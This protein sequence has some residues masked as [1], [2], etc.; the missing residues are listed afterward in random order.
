MKTPTR[1]EPILATHL[2]ARGARLGLPIAGNFELTARCNFSCP[3]CYVHK[4]DAAVPGEL[5]A[6]QWI[7][8]AGQARDAGMIF[9]LLTGGEPFVRKDFWEI[10]GA[11]QEMGLMVSINSNGSLIHGKTLERLL[12]DPPFRINISLYGGC[13]ETYRSMCGQASFASVVEAIRA[14]KEAGVDTRLNVSITPYNLQDLDR[15]WE[16]SQELG[17]HAKATSY[18]YPPVRVGGDTAH[19]LSPEEAAK[20]AVRWD[21]LRFTPEEFAHRAKALKSCEAVE[22]RE[23]AADLS[24]GVSCRA[25]STSFWLCWDGRMLPCGMMPGPEVRPLEQGFAQAWEQLRRE[26]AQ[27]RTPPKCAVC[28]SRQVCSTCAAVCVTETGRTDRVPEY[29]CRMTAETIRESWRVYQ[30]RRKG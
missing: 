24:E 16:I 23:C 21:M 7:S 14:L 15:I 26:T 11:M 6:E 19:R 8:L 1:S 10:Y 17:V 28:P 25:G 22:L 29:A 9:A 2:H 5:T 18:M 13:E 4:K 27:I 12:A 20:A 3:M 30:E